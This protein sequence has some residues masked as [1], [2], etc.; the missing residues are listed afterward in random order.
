MCLIYKCCVRACKPLRP[1]GVVA[2]RCAPP[3]FLRCATCRPTSS[4]CSSSPPRLRP[5]RLS[6]RV[7]PSARSS[8]NSTHCPRSDAYAR[9]TFCC[10]WIIVICIRT[11]G[12]GWCVPR[13]ASCTI[14]PCVVFV[15]GLCESLSSGGCSFG[16]KLVCTTA[17]RQGARWLAQR[18]AGLHNTVVA[19]RLPV[20]H[21]STDMFCRF[22][23][24]I[25]VLSHHIYIASPGVVAGRSGLVVQ[26]SVVPAA[27]VTAWCLYIYFCIFLGPVPRL[28]PLKNCLS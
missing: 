24:S 2:S 23:T 11:T 13:L 21:S 1:G 8:H 7:T 10:S 20:P 15:C 28:S 14:S 16:R 5:S 9:A 3:V 25:A 22:S 19:E 12:S 6:P 4:R 17:S 26:W 27:R 18:S